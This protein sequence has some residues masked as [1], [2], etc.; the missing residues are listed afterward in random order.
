MKLR[1][2]ASTLALAVGATIAAGAVAPVEALSF[3]LG[4]S[5][6][7]AP[8]SD[9][10]SFAKF[11]P[12]LGTLTGVVFTLS[13]SSAV[14]TASVTF[15]GAEGGTAQTTV[16]SLFRV[17][18]LSGIQISGN[19]SASTSCTAAN[20]PGDD[21]CSST[22]PVPG[23]PP[24]LTSPV[25]DTT[26]LGDYIGPSG[27]F[28]VFVTLDPSVTA[29]VCPVVNG[30][31]PTCTHSG[32]ASWSGDLSVEFQFLAEPPVAGVPEPT[33][34]SL[35][36]AGLLGLGARLLGLGAARRRREAR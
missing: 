5:A 22:S 32:S 26:D 33:T 29:S 15:S 1:R 21:T 3:S 7:G 10:L 24:T 14:T 23:T 30:A 2:N 17:E 6:T 27:F 12:S 9:T 36:G 8:D 19:G 18:T 25:T 13:D 34:L 31:T 4:A 35:L 20:G 11:D 28:D 16:G